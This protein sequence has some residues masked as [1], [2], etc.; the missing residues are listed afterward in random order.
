MF[1]FFYQR[2]WVQNAMIIIN[3]WISLRHLMQV[4]F[5]FFERIFNPYLPLLIITFYYY[6]KI[7][8]AFYNYTYCKLVYTVQLPLE[9]SLKF[10]YMS[11]K[12]LR[13]RI[14]LP[15]LCIVKLNSVCSFSESGMG[16][17]ISN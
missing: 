16:A 8:I 4:F 11:H 13:D 7:S 15:S 1:N 6:I 17:H 14:R 2:F 12:Y 5:F 9:I 10:L 3:Y